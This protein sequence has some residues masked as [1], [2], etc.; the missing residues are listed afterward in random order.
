MGQRLPQRP[1][2]SAPGVK[3]CPQVGEAASSGERQHLLQR[4]YS[5]SYCTSRRL[6][7]HPRGPLQIKEREKTNKPRSHTTRSSSLRPTI[8]HAAPNRGKAPPHRTPQHPKKTKQPADTSEVPEQPGP[9]PT[10]PH[11]GVPRATQTPQAQAGLPPPGCKAR[12]LR[13][14]KVNFSCHTVIQPSYTVAGL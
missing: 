12:T 8:T 4:P 7:P 5:G 3:T 10:H 13:S 9:A 6:P 1:W 14:C 2:P 11:C